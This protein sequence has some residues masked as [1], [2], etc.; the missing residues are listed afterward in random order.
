M[1]PI[2]GQPQLVGQRNLPPTMVPRPGGL[3][4]NVQLIPLECRQQRGFDF[5]LLKAS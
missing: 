5:R 4:F 1:Q 2:L 3:N